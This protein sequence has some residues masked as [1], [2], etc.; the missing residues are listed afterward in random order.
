MRERGP[1]LLGVRAVVQRVK[2]ARVR[3]GADVVGA[4]GLGVCAL[5]AVE[6]GE[7]PDEARRM[8]KRLWELRIFDD[9][10]GRANL[11]A[12]DLGL[13][14]LVV[15]QFSLLADTAGGRRPSYSRAAPRREAEG[16]FLA[17]V[18][19]LRERGAAVETGRFGAEMEVE[20][21]NQGPFTLIVDV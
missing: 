7:G 19:S 14:V 18:E 12:S 21:C 20:L 8:A 5:V 3:V 2:W 9:R 6:R 1:S 15:S 4:I 13:P 11:S 17:L 16:V 10:D